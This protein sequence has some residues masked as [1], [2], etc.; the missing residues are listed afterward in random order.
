MKT[1]NFKGWFA[2]IGSRTTPHDICLLMQDISKVF[3]A[4]GYGLSSGDAT[5]ADRAFWEGAIESPY[6][7]QIGARIYLSEAEVRG[8]KADPSNFFFNAL[9]FPT[10]PKAKEIASNAR[11]GFGGLSEWGINLH[12]RNTFQ[13]LG[14]NLTD[15]VSYLIYWAPTLPKEQVKGGTNTALQIAIQHKI[16]HRINLNTKKGMLWAESFLNSPLAQSVLKET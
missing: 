9:E 4:Q 8:R 11:G 12:T 10:H 16:K 7:R 15:P 6:Y 14:A 13:I 3:Y 2:G 5:G 1:P